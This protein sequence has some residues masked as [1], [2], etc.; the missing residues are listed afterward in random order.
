MLYEIKIYILCICLS[1]LF[2]IL[3]KKVNLK[4]LCTYILTSIF[5]IKTIYCL[6]FGKCYNEVYY[7]L[8]TYILVNILFVI[9][10]EEIEKLFI[11]IKNN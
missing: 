9:Y 4:I 7:L 10:Y 1:C 8:I 6:I 11:N 5:G 2:L 3:K